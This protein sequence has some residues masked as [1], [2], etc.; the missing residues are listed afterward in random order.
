MRNLPEN[1][2]LPVQLLHTAKQGVIFRFPRRNC[3]YC[4]FPRYR[5]ERRAVDGDN[6]T[7][8]GLSGFFTSAPIAINV[9][10]NGVECPLNRSRVTQMI[11]N[12]TSY[13][14]EDFSDKCH[15]AFPWSMTCFV[16]TSTENEMSRRVS[17]AGCNKLSINEWYCLCSEKFKICSLQCAGQTSAV[18]DRRVRSPFILSIPNSLRIGFTYPR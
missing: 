6:P 15:V 11:V 18:F 14:P 13:V 3:Y 17:T 4:S 8:G 12:C 1:F 9:S 2:T 16:S 5:D 7:R 10:M